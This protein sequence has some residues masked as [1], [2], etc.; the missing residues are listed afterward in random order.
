MGLD[1]RIKDERFDNAR[2]LLRLN[3]DIK[4]SRFTA[5]AMSKQSERTGNFTESESSDEDEIGINL[6]TMIDEVKTELKKELDK[7]L[8]NPET[9][10]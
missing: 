9:N 4:S 7:E 2:K 3:K 1:D 6:S 5:D 10:Q 8:N